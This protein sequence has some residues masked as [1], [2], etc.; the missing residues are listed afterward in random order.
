[1]RSL[2]LTA[3]TSLVFGLALLFRGGAE[4]EGGTGK[5]RLRLV[6]EKTGKGVAGIVRVFRQG[7]DRPLPLDGL[8]HRLRGLKDAE[9]LHWYVVP[10]EGAETTLPR[11]ALRLEALSGLE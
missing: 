9:A 6:D 1:M 4:P 3:V 2:L 11:A 5:G 8:P 10:A 7:E